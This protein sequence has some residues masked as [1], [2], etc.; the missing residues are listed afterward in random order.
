LAGSAQTVLT[1]Y[2]DNQMP[3]EKTVETVSSR[4]A[5]IH[6]AQAGC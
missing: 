6:P 2:R 1:V 4:A 3:I 5:L